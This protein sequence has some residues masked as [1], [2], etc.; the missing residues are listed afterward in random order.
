MRSKKLNY[1]VE[2]ITIS[3]FALAVVLLFNP[4]LDYFIS[5]NA[6]VL[7]YIWIFLF[8]V[9]LN[10]IYNFVNNSEG[11]LKRILPVL[12]FIIV[13][14]FIIES[15]GWLPYLFY[16]LLIFLFITVYRFWGYRDRKR[17]LIVDVMLGFVIILINISLSGLLG[18]EISVFSIIAFFIISFLLLL[19]FNSHYSDEINFEFSY[20][21]LYPV[22]TVFLISVVVIGLIIGYGFS[23]G[24]MNILAAGLNKLKEFLSLI[25]A[26]LSYPIV[27]LISLILNLIGERE[28]NLFGNGAEQKSYPERILVENTGVPDYI[29]N[30][31]KVLIVLFIIYYISRRLIRKKREVNNRDDDERE[32]LFSREE[33]ADDLRRI[34]DSLKNTFFRKKGR[35]YDRGNPLDLIRESY[36]KFL[37]CYSSKIQYQLYYTPEE[38]H[39]KLQRR[40]ELD[41]ELK[42]KA[43]ELTEIYN[44]ARY[45]AKHDQEKA[46]KAVKLWREL[47]SDIDV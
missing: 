2:I 28:T 9:L 15:L 4:W 35:S 24:L 38:Y 20:S 1:L 33:V 40:E 3:L 32:S 27:Y 12:I 47:Q 7:Q 37:L 42:D 31:V 39:G 22:M 11:L 23:D 17:K 44:Q 43:G 16:P 34:W 13:N 10:F 19:I 14:I 45:G 46:G 25:L 36:Y 21:L 41:E 5:N 8:M 18:F 29:V 26:F 30:I 6:S